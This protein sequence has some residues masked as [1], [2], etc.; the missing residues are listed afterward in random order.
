[1]SKNAIAAIAASLVVLVASGCAS[2]TQV[3]SSSASS[4]SAQ[5]FVDDRMDQTVVSIDKSL[6][7]L[8]VI[9]RGGEAP[10][11]PSAIADTVAGSD[12]HGARPAKPAIDVPSTA[13]GAR[14]EAQSL[15]AARKALASRTKIDWSGDPKDLL[16]SLSTGIGYHFSEVGSSRPLSP[17]KIRHENAAI[18]DVL[19]DI[20]KSV[21]GKADIRVITASRQIELVYH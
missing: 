20:A 13:Q 4:P 3:R 7:T 19:A 6:K 21:E 15:D 10:R 11:K 5:S 17:I 9:D 14:A 18:T 1:M 2:T 8:L 12:A 16:R